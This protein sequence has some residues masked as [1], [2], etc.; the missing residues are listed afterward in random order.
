MHAIHRP[1]QPPHVE[2]LWARPR[3]N[4]EVSPL[5][6]SGLAG[7]SS[8]ALP[9]MAVGSTAATAKRG[10]P[11]LR[12]RS[13]LPQRHPITVGCLCDGRLKRVLIYPRRLWRL[14][15]VIDVALAR[16]GAREWFGRSRKA[17]GSRTS[18]SH[19]RRSCR[20]RPGVPPEWRLISAAPCAS[21]QREDTED[22]RE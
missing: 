8:T 18:Q 22:E 9:S 20:K 17:S 21:D 19:S 13:W 15:R 14:Q 4:V 7:R 2:C 11:S 3:H 1:L 5:G 6:V 10:H 16:C 12:L